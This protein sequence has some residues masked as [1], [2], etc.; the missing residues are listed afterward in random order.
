MLQ[1]RPRSEEQWFRTGA[2]APSSLARTR[3]ACVSPLL[4]RHLRCI[5]LCSV[6]LRVRVV[7]EHT[8]ATNCMPSEK[9]QC[10]Q[11]TQMTK[12]AS[13]EQL[14]TNN[15]LVPSGNWGRLEKDRT[16]LRNLRTVRKLCSCSDGSRAEDGATSDLRVFDA[17][18]GAASA[19]LRR[20]RCCECSSA[21]RTVLRVQ[22]CAKDGAGATALCRGRRCGG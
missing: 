6:D 11:C 20:G 2:P 15:K 17:K 4:R 8:N 5:N 19:A 1:R 10:F 18:D 22:L 7:Y 9:S 21:P 3:W 12:Y 16:Y 13:H 14:R